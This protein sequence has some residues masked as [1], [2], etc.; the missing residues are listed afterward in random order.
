ERANLT[1]RNFPGTTEALRKKLKLKDGGD[2][3][4]FATTLQDG[5][6]VLLVTQKA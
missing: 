3:Y 1:L 6:H 2:T 4:L 5:K